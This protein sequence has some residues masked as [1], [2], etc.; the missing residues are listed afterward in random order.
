MSARQVS[1]LAVAVVC[2]AL[3]SRSV[4]ADDG[5]P[6]RAVLQEMGLGSMSVMADNDAVSIRGMGYRGGSYVSVSGRSYA[7]INLGPIHAGD[8]DQYNA[9]GKHEASG[10]SFSATGIIISSSGGY[11]GGCGCGGHYGK[12]STKSITVFAGGYSSAKAF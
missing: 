10:K 8:S 3:V 7:R 9:H 11:G 4:Q 12:T 1:V 2:V 6:S 5:V